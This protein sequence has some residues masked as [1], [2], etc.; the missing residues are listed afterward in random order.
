MVALFAFVVFVFVV[1]MVGFVLVLKKIQV[2]QPQKPKTTQ[3]PAQSYRQS[4]QAYI[5]QIQHI[6]PNHY[7]NYNIA[8]LM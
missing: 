7:N 6:N 1:V 4:V 8:E 3:K 2:T 5:R